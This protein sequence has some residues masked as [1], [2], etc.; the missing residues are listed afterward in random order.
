MIDIDR[1]GELLGELVDE[2]PEEFF[3]ELN[4]GVRVD[5]A[6]K[7]HPESRGDDLYILGEYET[8]PIGNGIVIYYGSFERLY[9]DLSDPALKKELRATLRHEFRHHMEGRAGERGLELQDERDLQEYHDSAP[10][11]GR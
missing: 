3:D 5:P 8:S 11:N 10:R 2:L 6:A 9:G 4:L 7:P 1:F